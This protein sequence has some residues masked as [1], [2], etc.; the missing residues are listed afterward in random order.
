MYLPRTVDVRGVTAQELADVLLR[1]TPELRPGDVVVE[2]G[3]P[4]DGIRLFVAVRDGRAI[5]SFSGQG[6]H[7]GPRRSF[8]SICYGVRS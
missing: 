6:V 4:S 2:A 8:Y 7:P 5:A 1:Y 3:F